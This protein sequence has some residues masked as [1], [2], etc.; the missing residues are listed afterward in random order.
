LSIQ[1]TQFQISEIPLKTVRPFEFD[2]LELATEATNDGN[3]L[4]LEDKD[5][6]TQF[7]RE[8]VSW[9]RRFHLTELT[10]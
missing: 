5:S 6:I 7:L 3:K 9:A 2:E 1:G 10:M 8:R 4:D